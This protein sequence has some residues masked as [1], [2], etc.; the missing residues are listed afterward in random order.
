[1]IGTRDAACCGTRYR[2]KNEA[3]IRLTKVVFF[4]RSNEGSITE[5]KRPQNHEQNRS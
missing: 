5:Q 4:E 1:M 3:I 2:Y